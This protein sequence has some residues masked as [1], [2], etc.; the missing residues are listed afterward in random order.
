MLAIASLERKKG[1][2]AMLKKLVVLMIPIITVFFNFPAIATMQQSEGDS[3]YLPPTPKIPVHSLQVLIREINATFIK[4]V[5]AMKTQFNHSA[6]GECAISRNIGKDDSDN[7]DKYGNAK[8]TIDCKGYIKEGLVFQ[9]ELAFVGSRNT[10]TIPQS[11]FSQEIEWKQVFLNEVGRFKNLCILIRG[12]G[13][14]QC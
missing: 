2:R 11:K 3:V 9:R 13:F 12:I 1:D 10:L 7:F 6:V 4:D 5:N 14:Q 8:L